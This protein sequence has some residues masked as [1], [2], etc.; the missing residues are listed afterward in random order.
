MLPIALPGLRTQLYTKLIVLYYS[1]NYIKDVGYCFIWHTKKVSKH[2]QIFLLVLV[3]HYVHC[4]TLLLLFI[5]ATVKVG[6]VSMAI[7][8]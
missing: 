4:F 6:V 2:G 3:H 8:V 5:I 7:L 1:S